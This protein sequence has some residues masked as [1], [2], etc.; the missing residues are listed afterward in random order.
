MAFGN[1]KPLVIS[2]KCSTKWFSSAQTGQPHGSFQ[3]ASLFSC[4]VGSAE[5]LSRRTQAVQEATI[6]DED[7]HEQNEFGA[8][9][10][11]S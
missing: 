1:A 5:I 7:Q 6:K 9:W 8:N 2:R 11:D 10:T 3:T 4:A